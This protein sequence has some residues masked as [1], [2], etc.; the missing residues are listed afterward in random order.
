MPRYVRRRSAYRK[1][2]SA[3][4][5]RY[6]MRKRYGNRKR[7]TSKGFVKINRHLPEIYVRNSSVAGTAQISDP[8]GTCIALGAPIADGGAAGTYSIPF[9]MTFRMDQIINSTDITNLCDQYKLRYFKV[10]MTYQ[11]TQA[12]V[13]GLAIMPNLTWIQDHDDN[14]VPPSVNALREKMGSRNVSFG[15]NKYIKIGVV[16]KCADTVF[17]NGITSAYSVPK[18]LWLNSTYAGVEH[19]GIK[20]ILNN[21]NLA[22]STTTATQFKFD[23]SAVVYGKDVQ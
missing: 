6:G 3:P 11:S 12:S 1:K 9:S 22:A 8:T 10:R 2:R 16:P 7:T 15:F 21:V 17:N 19:Y 13:G 20:G 4:R 18:S 23:I 14:V 5:R